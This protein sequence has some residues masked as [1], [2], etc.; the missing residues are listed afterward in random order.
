[1]IHLQ[2]LGKFIVS[3]PV[4]ILLCVITYLIIGTVWYGPLF[5]KAWTKMNGIDITTKK[6]EDMMRGMIEGMVMSIITGF[7]ITVVLGRGMEI[8]LIQNWMQ[9][10]II[11]TILWLPFTALPFAQN[12][13]YLQK[14]KKLLL[15][16]A[17]YMLI[18]LWAM[19][20][21]LYKTVV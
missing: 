1:M 15:I 16:D 18:S 19:S 10:M 11:A 9:P 20:L 6:K 21:I 5:S 7:V 17:G 4:A 12:Y 2:M 3:H 13:A 14:P 8:L